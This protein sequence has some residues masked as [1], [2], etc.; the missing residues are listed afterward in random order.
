MT[1]AQLEAELRRRLQD[2][3][4]GAS[5]LDSGSLAELLESARLRLVAEAVP[6]L[7]GTVVTGDEDGVA[8]S[9]DVVDGAGFLLAAQVALVEL[10][11]RYRLKLARGEF[12]VSWRSGLEAESS[13]D[14]SAAFRR[15]LE[16][17]AL[18]VSH[19]VLHL[20]KASFATR[21][22]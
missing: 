16:K 5:E 1:G 6:G 20:T 10:S 14:A 17:L 4:P 19:W 18:E 7:S 13:I 15:E 8:L 12:G 21:P 2:V 11:D 9:V 22:Q 3:D